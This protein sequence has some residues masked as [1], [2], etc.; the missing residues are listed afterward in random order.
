M[1]SK[2][3]PIDTPSRAAAV[4]FDRLR[5]ERGMSVRAVFRKGNFKARERTSK[6]LSGEGEWT[7]EDVDKFA[8]CFEIPLKK[9]F[10]E[11]EKETAILL[12]P[13]ECPTCLEGTLAS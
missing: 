6:L 2:A 7:L 12:G 9:A 10:L 4:V 5:V 3:L 13:K 8:K 11:I 1:G